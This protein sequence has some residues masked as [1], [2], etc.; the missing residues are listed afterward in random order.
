M[1]VSV[2]NNKSKHVARAIER[3]IGSREVQKFKK[4]YQKIVNE[5]TKTLTTIELK[6]H[7]LSIPRLPV[8]EEELDH[9][10]GQV[11]LDGNGLIRE[12]EFVIV[13]YQ[14]NLDSFLWTT[15]RQ[16]YSPLQD[17]KTC[18]A[19]LRITLDEAQSSSW[20][21]VVAVTIFAFIGLSCTCFCFE[22]LLSLRECEECQLFFVVVE[23]V[24][25]VVFTVELV[26]RLIVA[27][28]PKAVFTDALMYCDF[29]SIVPVFIEVFLLHAANMDAGEVRPTCHTSKNCDER[30]KRPSQLIVSSSLSSCLLLFCIDKC[31][32]FWCPSRS[33]RILS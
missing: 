12:E 13:I 28:S 20:A 7:L 33:R 27:S 8:S 30:K 23:Y 21:M 3:E 2:R 6:K 26:A 1:S 4:Y 32:P 9:M 29:F 17:A 11:D 22:T 18:K 25:T 15:S 14:S 19:R 31:F 5:R 24:S 10:I 16:K